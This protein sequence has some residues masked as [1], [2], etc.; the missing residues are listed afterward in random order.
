[1]QNSSSGDVSTTPAQACTPLETRS[2]NAPMQTPAV[3]G[4]NRTCGIRSNTQLDVTV[5]ARG[6]DHPWAVEPLP[7]GDLLVTEKPGRLRIISAGGTIGQPIT[8]LPAVDARGQGGLLDVALSPSFASDRTI[9]WSYAEPGDGGNTTAVARGLLSAD[10]ASLSNVSVIFRVVP[11]YIGVMHFGSR[12]AWAPDG[13]LLI[14]TGERSNSEMRPYA[15]SLQ[16]HLGK[17]LRINPDGSTPADNPFVGR[18]DALPQIYSLGHRNIQAAS[19]D[20]QGRLWVIEHGTNGGDELNLIEIGKN[21]G[22][23]QQAYG[24][25]YNGRA[26]AG[27]QTVRDGMQQPVYYWDPVIAP[28][29]AQ[30]YTGDAFAAWKGNLLVGA[31]REKRLVRLVIANGRV[32]GEEHLLNDRGQRIRDVRQGPDGFLYIVTDETDGQLWRVAPRR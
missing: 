15:Q 5:V 9:F 10:R 29:G 6:L 20:A 4:Q 21:Y 12:L 32:T 17:V 23:P 30:W 1:M 19:V 14:T 13:T 3:A 31:L 25:E 7:G 11:R 18:A 16:S 22:W 28:S 26:I 27:A 2:A 8:G 24:V